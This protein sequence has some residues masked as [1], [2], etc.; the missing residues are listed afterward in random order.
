MKKL[1][2]GLSILSLCSLTFS[3]CESNENVTDESEIVTSDS[4][5]DMDS[6]MRME[7]DRTEMDTSVMK[8]STTVKSPRMDVSGQ[9]GDATVK[10]SYGAPSMRGRKIWGGLV[11]YDSVWRTG[12]NEA[13][14]VEFSKDVMVE[15]KSLPAGKYS[16]FTIPKADMGW[17][18]IFNKTHNQW[19][20]Y[21]YKKSDDALRVNVIADK[22]TADV[23][24]MKFDITST[25]DKK[26]TITL[27]WEKMIAPIDVTVK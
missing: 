1:I 19:G 3:A 23:E 18:F 4:Q 20:A 15:G 21:E 25:G 17:E 8:S 11:N 27:R 5:A 14:T 7:K 12:A 16:I 13:T 10:I 22:G 26:G 9:I 2:Y 6:A 24:Q